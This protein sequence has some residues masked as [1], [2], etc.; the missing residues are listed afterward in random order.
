[1]GVLQVKEFATETDLL[2]HYRAVNAR[3][4]NPPA[5]KLEVMPPKPDMRKIVMEVIA[6]RAA[7]CRDDASARILDELK[8]PV[9]V[10]ALLK[11][12]AGRHEVT[13]GEILG[14]SR[15]T[16][17]KDARWEAIILV[18]AAH[19]LWSLPKIGRLFNKDHTTILHCLKQSGMRPDLRP[20]ASNYVAP[21]PRK[22]IPEE[23]IQA[24]IREY[25]SRRISQAEIGC[26]FG[27][28]THRVR[29]IFAERGVPTNKYS[30]P[31][32]HT[33]KLTPAIVREIK[34]YTQRGWD[35]KQIWLATGGVVGIRQLQGVRSGRCWAHVT[36]SS[37]DAA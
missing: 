27:L 12:V 30:M 19:P 16:K 24:M 32:P 5:P 31:Q 8:A 20:R 3:T 6:A 34:D 25:Q 29:A 35:N 4:F 28:T 2:A 22:L 21:I 7:E 26:L 1:M 36:L 9:S 23:T 11:E 18:H 15:V 17:I 33:V 13:V 37:G 14:P 10:K